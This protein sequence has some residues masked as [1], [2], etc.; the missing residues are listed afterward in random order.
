[1]DSGESASSTRA[2]TEMVR[3]VSAGRSN[4]TPINTIAV[5]MKERWVATSAPD[6]NR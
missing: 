3:S 1:M 6:S 2:A 4:I 5:M